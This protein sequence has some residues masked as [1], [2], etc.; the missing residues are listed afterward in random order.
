MPWGIGCD[1]LAVRFR[2]VP[3]KLPAVLRRWAPRTDI[4]DAGSFRGSA[5]SMHCPGAPLEVCERPDSNCLRKQEI[6]WFPRYVLVFP[7]ASPAQ[8]LACRVKDQELKRLVLKSDGPASPAQ[9]PCFYIELKTAETDNAHRD[10]ALGRL[11]VSGIKRGYRNSFASS[12]AQ[13]VA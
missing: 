3:T 9:F 13:V 4:L 11:R 5:D 12:S 2:P 10:G 8:M 7:R 1:G 6:G